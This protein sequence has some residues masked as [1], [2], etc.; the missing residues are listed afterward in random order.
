MYI[1]SVFEENTIQTKWNK[2][3]INKELWVKRFDNP[4]YSLS[5]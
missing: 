2:G 4:Y 3:H 5:F 1:L